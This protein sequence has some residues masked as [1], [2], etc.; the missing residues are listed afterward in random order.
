MAGKRLVLRRDDTCA[1]C[2]SPLAAGSTAQ[3]DLVTWEIVCPACGD[4]AGDAPAADEVIDLRVPALLEPRDPLPLATLRAST[5]RRRADTGSA[6][7]VATIL[8]DAPHSSVRSGSGTTVGILA[9][10]LGDQAILLHGRRIPRSPGH[11]D[12]LAVAASGV[13]IIDADQLR[14]TVERR[15]VGGYF[16]TELRLFVGGRDRT[17][18]IDRL[19]WQH[20]ALVGVLADRTVPV[21]A[22]LCPD[23][24]DWPTTATPFQLDDV[25]V[26]WPSD[27]AELIGR[28]GPLT[29]D[30]VER[31]ARRLADE[32]PAR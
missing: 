17:K 1:G 21:H 8:A 9:D 28:P 22:A 11:I 18:D 14:G 5:E 24:A 26:T 20:G 7:S 19:V 2:A 12:H 6:G 10:R 31:V 27:L 13:W 4:G 3:W 32:L 15:D 16:R 23:G 29:D 25:W 30:D